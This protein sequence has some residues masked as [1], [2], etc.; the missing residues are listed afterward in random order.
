VCW[1]ALSGAPPNLGSPNCELA[2]CIACDDEQSGAAFIKFA[3]HT[4]R[5]SGLV[6]ATV[7]PCGE[8]GTLIQRARTASPT[9]GTYYAITICTHRSCTHRSWNRVACRITAR[10]QWIRWNGCACTIRRGGLC[11]AHIASIKSS[12]Y[13]YLHLLSLAC[14]I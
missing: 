13:C 9:T 14:S 11:A 1:H 3:G 6:S 4:G 2:D 7:R 10:R 5:G 8:V 12:Y